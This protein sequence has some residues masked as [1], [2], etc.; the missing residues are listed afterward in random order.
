MFRLILTGKM[1][2]EVTGP[3]GRNP[4]SGNRATC[5]QVGARR[6][7]LSLTQIP[8]SVV[9]LRTV[10]SISTT[11]SVESTTDLSPVGNPILKTL[12]LG[13]FLFLGAQERSLI[14]NSMILTFCAPKQTLC[15]LM[16]V[17]LAS[18]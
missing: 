5:M 2:V 17:G 4:M 8:G 11:F 10:S 7:K 13:F 16:F 6:S 9:S 15:I 1:E 3:I 12:N 14:G 18:A